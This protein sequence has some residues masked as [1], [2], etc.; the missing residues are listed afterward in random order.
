MANNPDVAA[1]WRA[2]A[3]GYLELADTS[4]PELKGSWA[5]NWRP[6]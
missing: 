3:D 2:S 5:R 1:Q 6:S 4:V